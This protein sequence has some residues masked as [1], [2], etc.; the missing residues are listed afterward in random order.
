MDPLTVLTVVVALVAAT[1][2]YRRWRRAQSARD[3][4]A[5]MLVGQGWHIVAEDQS[6]SMR[7][8]RGVFRAGDERRYR[9][10]ARGF[11]RGFPAICCD[12]LVIDRDD[13][14][15]RTTWYTVVALQLPAPLPRVEL[16][17]QNAIS[18]FVGRL[19]DRDIT[20]ES[21]DFNRRYVVHANDRSWA[22]QM[23]T[24]RTIDRL[25][26]LPAVHVCTEANDLLSVTRGTLGPLQVMARLG[27]LHTVASGV[28][29]YVWRERGADAATLNSTKGATQ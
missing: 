5:A 23:L 9:T 29:D 13:K 2:T 22:Y 16:T 1:V 17:P 19:T 15:R 10:V 6:L 11:Y 18:G 12:L 26:S 3:R 4:R 20:V 28:P 14:S 27:V 21:H 8:F 25:T 7:W 24:P